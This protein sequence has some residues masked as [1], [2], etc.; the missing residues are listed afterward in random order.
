MDS[1]AA[2]PRQAS[3]QGG[4]ARPQPQS[5]LKQGRPLPDQRNRTP[6]PTPYPPPPANSKEPAP[7]DLTMD[8]T[9]FHE[10]QSEP[11]ESKMAL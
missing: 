7:A 8:A 1:W 5:G 4:R 10:P 9:E 11:A 2:R 3:K 6:P